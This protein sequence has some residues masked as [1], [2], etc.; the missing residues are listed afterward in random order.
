MC[1]IIMCVVDEELCTQF[2]PA[3]A[4]ARIPSPCLCVCCNV[5]YAVG[6]KSLCGLCSVKV[7]FFCMEIGLNTWLESVFNNM[8]HSVNKDRSVSGSVSISGCFFKLIFS[9]LCS[10]LMFKVITGMNVAAWAK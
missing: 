4:G 9:F 8:F 6:M 7:P 10:K 5:R 3:S 2:P 1:R